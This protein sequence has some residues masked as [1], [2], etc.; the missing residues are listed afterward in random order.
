[1]PKIDE[2]LKAAHVAREEL[3]RRK[4]EELKQIKEMKYKNYLKD[5]REKSRNNEMPLS[6]TPD[7]NTP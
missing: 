5:L 7:G 1:M 3:E 6:L 4:V 2:T